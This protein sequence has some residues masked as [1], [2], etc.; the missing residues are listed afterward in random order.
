MIRLF[1]LF[2]EY[3]VTKVAYIGFKNTLNYNTKILN[4]ETSS[5]AI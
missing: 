4:E 3:V 5:F 2:Y 1:L